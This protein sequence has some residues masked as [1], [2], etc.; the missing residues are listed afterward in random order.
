MNNQIFHEF[1]EKPCASKMVIPYKSAHS[2]KMKMAVLVEEVVR[3]M[4]NAS[5][6]LDAEVT[7]RVMA[8]W[9]RKLRRSGYPETV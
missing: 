5:R 4:R 6:G 3:R 1:Y 8:E 2:R 7:R 9:S